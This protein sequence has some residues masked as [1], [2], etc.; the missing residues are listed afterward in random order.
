VAPPASIESTAS[1]LEGIKRVNVTSPVG[2][3]PRERT[4]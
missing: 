2:S 1:A 4:V 3:G